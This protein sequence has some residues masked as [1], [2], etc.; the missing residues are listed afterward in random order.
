MQT[1]FTLNDEEIRQILTES[2]TIALVGYSHNPRRA[3][4]QTGKFL[5]EAGYWVYAVNPVVK[6]IDGEK[7]YHSLAELPEA[8]DI[9]NVFRRSEFLAEIVDAAIAI[10]AKTVWAQ[11]EIYDQAA[12]LKAIDAGLNVIMDAC[13]K[14]EYLRLGLHQ[15]N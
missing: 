8:I 12:A 2:K 6:E 5:R 1:I 14:I 3:S 9:V 15:L 11:L 10:N 4:Y 7:C 13:I